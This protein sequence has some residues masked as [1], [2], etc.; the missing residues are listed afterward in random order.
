MKSLLSHNR[1][2]VLYLFILG[3]LFLVLAQKSFDE[4]VA[5]L[6]DN[7]NY[8]ILGS[9]LAEGKG[10]SDLHLKDAPAHNHY[11]PGYPAM[12]A[13]IKVLGGDV[14]AVKRVNQLFLAACLLLVFVLTRKMVRS[15]HL[16]LVVSLLCLFNYHLLKFSTIM[17]SEISFLL[18]S[19]LTLFW[20]LRQSWDKVWYK[21]RGFWV[22]LLLLSAGVYLRAAGIALVGATVLWFFFNQ[23]KRIHALALFVGFLLTMLPWQLRSFA[24]GGSSY[25]KQLL[26]INPYAPE[27]GGLGFTSLIER[28]GVNA[29][30][31]LSVEIPSGLF[32]FFRVEEY[33]EPAS[34]TAWIVGVILV[35]TII[36]GLF[37]LQQQYRSLITW[38]LLT[39][40]GVLLC[41]P[42]VWQGVRF[43]LPLVP[44]L[45]LLFVYGIH[46]LLIQ[47][48][49][50]VKKPVKTGYLDPVLLGVVLLLLWP[51][52]H[53]LDGL[54]KQSRTPYSQEFQHYYKVAKWAEENLPDS[55]LICTRKGELFYLEAKRP[56]IRYQFTKDFNEQL[57]FLESSGVDYVVA[58][59]LGFSSTNDY[60]LPLIQNAPQKFEILY[61]VEDPN[62][63]LLKF[64]PDRGYKGEWKGVQK[65]GKG[66]FNYT[67]G[68]R[69]EG[70]WIGNKKEGRGTMYF[71]KDYYLE[72]VWINDMLEGAAIVYN[73]EGQRI[74]S[75]FVPKPID[76]QLDI[77]DRQLYPANEPK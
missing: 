53:S 21:D 58:A 47:L 69:F 11:P 73:P 56:T 39:S 34:T 49:L 57:A 70:N 54:F 68:R 12:I 10:Y 7:A 66:I 6:G 25:F 59:Y 67:D 42:S 30:R 23:K 14:Q 33:S 65:E 36:W 77:E 46:Q 72:G 32:S 2:N 41:W 45:L 64:H 37:R 75:V 29:G 74:D 8:Y 19:L 55:A 28:I 15:L 24:L 20:L 71:E 9:A 48:I 38:Y 51:Y 40:F 26:L 5:N 31:Y 13:A 18:I 27:E 63:Y 52:S 61:S 16:A 1:L 43:M 3:G 4:K 62:A 60:L 76:P 17:M 44:L 35:V 50:L 22:L